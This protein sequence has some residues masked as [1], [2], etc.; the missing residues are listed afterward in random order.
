MIS[1]ENPR[2]S[3]PWMPSDDPAGLW[4][5][6]GDP[7]WRILA[8]SLCLGTAPQLCSWKV[9]LA[10]W[11]LLVLFLSILP[12]FL[13]P[14]WFLTSAP[15]PLSSSLW[16]NG[17]YLVW[18]RVWLRTAHSGSLHSW[19]Q[20]TGSNV[21]RKKIAYLLNTPRLPFPYSL[22]NAG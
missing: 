5:V 11:G 21:I 19:I 9:L 16:G 3:P 2:T 13:C 7:P 4:F 10:L 14:G 18:L 20:P 12:F 17:L 6:F 22:S 8:A 1:T 15:W